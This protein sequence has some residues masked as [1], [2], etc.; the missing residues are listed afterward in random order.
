[1]AALI[2][3]D[4]RWASLAGVIL[5]SDLNFTLGNAGDPHRTPPARPLRSRQTGQNSIAP[6]NSLPQLGQVRWGS[7]LILLTAPQSKP[8]RTA[9]PHSHRLVRNRPAQRL[10]ILLSHCASNRKL[11]YT[12]ALNRISEQNF[13]RSRFAVSRVDFRRYR[14]PS[15]KSDDNI[16]LLGS[17]NRLQGLK[18]PHALLPLSGPCPGPPEIA[19]EPAQCHFGGSQGNCKASASFPVPRRAPRASCR[20]LPLPPL[21]SPESQF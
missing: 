3:T 21:R 8:R 5:D 13:W 11:P 14:K 17:S 20:L 18:V 16:Q 7:A 9:T 6:E 12:S 4:L 10:C 1:M 19:R 15:G 2:Y